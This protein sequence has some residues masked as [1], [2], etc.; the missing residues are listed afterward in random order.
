[1]CG[2]GFGCGYRRISGA[3]GNRISGIIAQGN[4]SVVLV[5][6]EFN[7]VKSYRYDDFD[8]V[9]ESSGTGYESFTNEIQYTGAIYD[10]TTGLLYLNARYYDPTTGRFI[11]RD[12]YRGEQNS[13][14]TWHLYVYCA[15]NPINFVDPDGHLAERIIGALTG[16]MISGAIELISE[17]TICAC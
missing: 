1:M 10:E 5:D 4:H 13:P 3:V 2:C 11:S 7:Q 17:A 16:A 15:N 9:N 14:D 12:T 6:S 8:N